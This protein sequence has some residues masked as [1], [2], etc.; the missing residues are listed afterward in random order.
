MLL[1][2]NRFGQKVFSLKTV[3]KHRM[4]IDDHLDDY[5]DDHLDDYLDDHLL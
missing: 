5:L 3:F 1:A 4:I 2:R